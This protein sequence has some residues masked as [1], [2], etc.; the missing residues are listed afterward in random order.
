[1][2]DAGAST[3]KA[4]GEVENVVD[5]VVRTIQEGVTHPDGTDGFDPGEAQRLRATLGDF[6]RGI[7]SAARGG[8]SDIDDAIDRVVETIGR[9]VIHPS[10]SGGFGERQSDELRKRFR[11][12]A[13]AIV[14]TARTGARGEVD[15][16]IDALA[17]ALR[18]GLFRVYGRASYAA[19]TAD[20]LTAYFETFVDAVLTVVEREG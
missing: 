12:L 2:G 19:I 15:P 1:M 6:A 3:T 16:A 14:E 9:G 20:Q 5:E 11:A 8:G 10:T 4:R 7:V 17:R 18:R 13:D